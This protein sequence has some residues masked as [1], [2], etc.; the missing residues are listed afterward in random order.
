MAM[1]ALTAATS[2]R[3]SEAVAHLDWL[4]AH[5][6]PLGVL[7]EKVDEHGDAAS[8]AP[9]GWTASIVLLTLS[10]LE[11]PLPIPGAVQAPQT[12]QPPKVS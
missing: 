3:T 9:L 7:S 4:A 6:T 10:A 11:R 5:R 1:F 2:G 8:V 12:P